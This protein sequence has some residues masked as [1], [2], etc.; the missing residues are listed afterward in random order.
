MYC[1]WFSFDYDVGVRR[2]FFIAKGTYANLSTSRI[3]LVIFMRLWD[4]K[5]IFPTNTILALFSE[6][7][8]AYQRSWIYDDPLCN[9]LES[10]YAKPYTNSVHNKS[11]IILM[12]IKTSI[13]LES[14][15]LYTYLIKL[16]PNFPCRSCYRHL[17]KVLSKTANTPNRSQESVNWAI[18]LSFAFW[19]ATMCSLLVVDAQISPFRVHHETTIDYQDQNA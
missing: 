16:P 12:Y 5:C 11:A 8:C 14:I 6:F 4:I 18:C 15:S 1:S 19:P 17:P 7:L 3:C 13:V 9:R 2:V 10:T